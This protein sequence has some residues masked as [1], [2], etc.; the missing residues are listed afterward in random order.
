MCQG[1]ETRVLGLEFWASPS[2]LWKR[3]GPTP[4]PVSWE[5]REMS[6]CADGEIIKQ[7]SS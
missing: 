5:E 7:E 2:L 3:G 1:Q 6:D 4:D